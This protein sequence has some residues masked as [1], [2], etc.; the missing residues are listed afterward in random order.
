MDVSTS[1]VKTR[2]PVEVLKDNLGDAPT[3]QDEVRYKIIIHSSE[4]DSLVRL[5]FQFKIVDRQNTRIYMCSDFPGD[6]DLQ[7][8]RKW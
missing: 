2:D 4:D 7:K 1:E 5:L 8:V 6:S 3:I